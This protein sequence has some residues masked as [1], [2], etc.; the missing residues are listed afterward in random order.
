M[1]ELVVEDLAD[2]EEL[3]AD[4]LL[5][6]GIAYAKHGHELPQVADKIGVAQRSE[7]SSDTWPPA[8]VPTAD[9]L[10]GE[11]KDHLSFYYTEA[12]Y[13]TFLKFFEFLKGKSSFDYDEW[14]APRKLIQA[15]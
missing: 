2:G 13:E 10:L 14:R 9:Y 8:L 4:A 11:V 3:D 15:L 7:I 1:G 5:P 12:E 6:A